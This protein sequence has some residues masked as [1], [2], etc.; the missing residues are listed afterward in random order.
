[1]RLIEVSCRNLIVI[2]SSFLSLVESL[3]TKLFRILARFF[4]DASSASPL[5]CF[6]YTKISKAP[7]K[8]FIASFEIYPGTPLFSVYS[9]IISCIKYRRAVVVSRVTLCLLILL[10]VHSASDKYYFTLS[11]FFLSLSIIIVISLRAPL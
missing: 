3:D 2:L 1:M 6:I 5:T 10:L 7:A 4:L 11:Y 9:P 8:I